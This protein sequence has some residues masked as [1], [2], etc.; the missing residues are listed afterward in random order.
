MSEIESSQIDYKEQ[1]KK[2][3]FLLKK[4]CGILIPSFYIYILQINSLR[5]Y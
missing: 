2:D 5:T 3:A 4:Q 1:N